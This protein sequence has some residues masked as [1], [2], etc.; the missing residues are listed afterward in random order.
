MCRVLPCW[1]QER[2]RQSVGG[3]IMLQHVFDSMPQRR[4][5]TWAESVE[6]AGNF[7]FA[8]R[9]KGTAKDQGAASFVWNQQRTMS[10]PCCSEAGPILFGLDMKR[11]SGLVIYAS[12]SL[13]SSQFCFQRRRKSKQARASSWRWW[14]FPIQA[15]GEQELAVQMWA[16]K[17]RTPK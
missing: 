6:P 9:Q 3:C 4:A 2:R 7:T 12:V 11:D 13:T 1:I 16:T 15:F 17:K 10:R 8:R 5:Q 14:H